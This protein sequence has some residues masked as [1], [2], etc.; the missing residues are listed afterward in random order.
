VEDVEMDM[1]KALE[2]L[3]EQ[4]QKIEGIRKRPA[5]NPDYMIWNNTAIKI[6]EQVFSADLVEMF[7][8]AG[9]RQMS[10][11]GDHSY[12]LY[13]KTLEEKKQLLEGFIREHERFAGTGEAVV[14]GG[15]PLGIYKL[16]SEIAK[17]SGKLLD[18]GHFAPAVEEAFKRVINEVKAHMVRKGEDTYDGG[19]SLVGHALGIDNRTP[20]IKFNPLIKP[21]EKD[22]QR[23]IMHLFMGIVGIRN[24]KAH[25]NVVLDSPERTVEY[26]GLASLL[27]RL[28]DLSPQFDNP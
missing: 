27:M 16:H 15:K 26:L 24:M 19:A 5:F 21:E 8:D 10:I 4:L 13:L 14:A 28:L 20:P 9:P 6:M 2:L 22:E 11:N 1:G 25:L 12:H 23:G 3:R 7:E 17:V 18:D